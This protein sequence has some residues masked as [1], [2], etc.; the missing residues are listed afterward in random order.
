VKVKNKHIFS[1]GLSGC[2]TNGLSDYSYAEKTTDLSQ[3]TD[4]LPH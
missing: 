1:G 2:R 4:K 3:V